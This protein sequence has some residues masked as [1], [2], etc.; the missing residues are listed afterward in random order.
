MFPNVD[1]TTLNRHMLKKIWTAQSMDWNLIK[2]NWKKRLSHI[3]TA[4]LIGSYCYKINWLERQTKKFCRWFKECL[5]LKYNW[6]GLL[7]ICVDATNTWSKLL[8]ERAASFPSI[9]FLHSNLS[10]WGYMY[11]YHHATTWKSTVVERT[12]LFFSVYLLHAHQ[13][14]LTSHQTVLNETLVKRK[15]DSHVMHRSC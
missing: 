11:K 6:Q 10:A 1:W 8:K 14:A 5:A 12:T 7:L 15:W 9:V 2:L 13:P 3:W 4:L